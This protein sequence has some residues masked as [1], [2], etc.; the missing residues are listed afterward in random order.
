MSGEKRTEAPARQ[1]TRT[2]RITVTGAVDKTA[3][4]HD[5]SIVGRLR[6]SCR[7]AFFLRVPQTL[8]SA[9]MYI[10]A[11]LPSLLLLRRRGGGGR[12]RS[13]E[14]GIQLIAT[15]HAEKS[16]SPVVMV[17]VDATKLITERDGERRCI[18]VHPESFP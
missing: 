4:P 13:G 17:L 7:F 5:E 9:M 14:S 11:D 3:S 15:E 6:L 18:T 8:G 2:C 12:A 16:T 1:T 10:N